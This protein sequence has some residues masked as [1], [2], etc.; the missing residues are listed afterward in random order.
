[1]GIDKVTKETYGAKLDENLN[2][3]MQKIRRGTY[4]PKPAR[5]TQI[6]KEDGSLRPLAISCFE[7]KLVQLAVSTILNKIYEPIFLPCSY[8]FRPDQSCHD[9]LRALNKATF[10]NQNGTIIEI[11]LRKYFNRIPHYELMKFLRNK[12]SDKRFLRLIEII[13][14]MPTIERN[15]ETPNILGCP[16]GSVATP[17]TMLQTI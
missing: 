8:G 9:A 1:V 5:I 12:I 15:I 13:I 17:T 2:T 16:Q 4:K 7:D 6:P 11:D 3:L 10:K 14:T